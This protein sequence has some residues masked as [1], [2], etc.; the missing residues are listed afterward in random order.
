MYKPDRNGNISKNKSIK[1]LEQYKPDQLNSGIILNSNVNS[2][3]PSNSSVNSEEP[4]NSSVNSEEP[5]NSHKLIMEIEYAKQEVLRLKLEKLQMEID[6]KK[7]ILKQ[8]Q[9]GQKLPASEYDKIFTDFMHDNIKVDKNG[10]KYCDAS[11]KSFSKWFNNYDPTETSA[12][13]NQIIMEM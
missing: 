9:A 7:L 3:E 8:K 12:K 6:E 11:E 10:K 1:I 4:S 2:E 13:K 5:S